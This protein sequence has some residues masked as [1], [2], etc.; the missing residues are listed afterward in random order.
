MKISMALDRRTY[1]G[2]PVD[3]VRKLRADAIHM[4]TRDVD[5]YMR[6]VVARLRVER[7]AEIDIGGDSLEERC[8]S[9]LAGAIRSRMAL[10][11]FQREYLDAHAIRVLRRARRITQ[12]RLAAL[13]GVSFATVNRW[14]AGAHL[15]SSL[16]SVEQELF[17]YFSRTDEDVDEDPG[18]HASPPAPHAGS[19][20][21]ARERARQSF[22]LPGRILGT[23]RSKYP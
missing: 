7:Q 3:I 2:A 6:V 5:A 4:K 20:I 1:A 15:P 10:P 12:E 23:T 8:E 21:R 9:F 17:T 16:R 19:L 11:V 22:R 14:E 13:L 18:V